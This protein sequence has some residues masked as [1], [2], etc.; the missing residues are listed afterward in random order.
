M[1]WIEI[2]KA[3]HAYTMLAAYGLLHVLLEHIHKD[4]LV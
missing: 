2:I 3:K 4:K 1:A